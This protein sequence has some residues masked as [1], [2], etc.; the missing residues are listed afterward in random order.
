MIRT[1]SV[2]ALLSVGATLTYAQNMDAIKQRRE[3][4]R[5][6][7]TAGS[8]PFKMSKGEVPFQLAKVQAMLKA[9]QDEL[10]KLKNLFPDDSKTGGDT[11]ASPK[12]WQAKAEFEAAIDTL[13]SLSK[14]AANAITDEATFKAEY[15]KVARGCNGCHKR[16]DGFAPR[17]SESLKK[18]KQ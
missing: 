3:V 17:L 4:M 13:I 1:L 16:E 18:L 12:I 8:D 6:I 14:A 5:T 2:V 7:G 11:D 15:P 9:Y 10:P